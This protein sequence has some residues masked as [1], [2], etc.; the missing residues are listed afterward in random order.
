MLPLSFAEFVE[1]HGFEIKET[2]SA[3]GGTRKVAVDQSGEK[4]ALG[5]VFDAY[6]R[7]GGMPGIADVGLDQEKVLVLL[8]GI[9]SSGVVRDVLERESKR[10]RKQITDPILLRKIIKLLPYLLIFSILF[11]SL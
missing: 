9:F 7:F 1:F 11:F 3:L 2:V 5:E 6:V 8:D 4:Y 10:G